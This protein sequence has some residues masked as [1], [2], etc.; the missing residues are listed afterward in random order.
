MEEITRL[1]EASVD[2]ASDE[3]RELLQGA[4]ER[5]VRRKFFSEYPMG[6]L[7]MENVTDLPQDKTSAFH[8]CN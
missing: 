3:V 4:D 8:G 5:I 1:L 7:P 6:Q 2:W